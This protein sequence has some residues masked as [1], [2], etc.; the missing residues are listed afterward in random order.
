MLSVLGHL[1]KLN[2]MLWIY[3]REYSLSLRFLTARR[4]LR[5]HNSTKTRSNAMRNLAQR[6]FELR[7]FTQPA[8]ALT[9]HDAAISYNT[10]SWSNTTSHNTPLRKCTFTIIAVALTR[11]LYITYWRLRPSTTKPWLYIQSCMSK[12]RKVVLS[13][14]ITAK[15]LFRDNLSVT[16]CIQNEYI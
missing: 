6:A 13:C 10:Y 5:L 8:W 4:K 12:K 16:C 3:R 7:F 1:L 14:V 15:P 9:Q 11:H 2:N